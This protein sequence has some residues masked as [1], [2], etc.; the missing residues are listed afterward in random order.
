MR[1]DTVARTVTVSLQPQGAEPTWLWLVRL[2]V[3][4]D[5]TTEIFPGTQRSYVVRPFAGGVVSDAI[6]VTS[7]DRTG[8]ESAAVIQRLLAPPQR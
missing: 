5:W 3:G 8:N 4:T 1:P 6:S 7:V 2:R